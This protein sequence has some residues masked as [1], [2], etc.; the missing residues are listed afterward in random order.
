MSIF[1]A[2]DEK[3][4]HKHVFVYLVIFPRVTVIYNI[5]PEWSGYGEKCALARTQKGTQTIFPTLKV[6]SRDP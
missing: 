5:C 2:L 4:W 1:R 3:S 6:I